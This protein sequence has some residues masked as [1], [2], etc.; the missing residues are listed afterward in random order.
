MIISNRNLE[1]LQEQIKIGMQKIIDHKQFNPVFQEE[2]SNNHQEDSGVQIENLNISMNEDKISPENDR[3]PYCIVWTALPF[4]TWII[5]IIGHTGIALYFFISM[6]YYVNYNNTILRSNGVIHDFAGPYFISVDNFAFGKP[7]K[8]VKIKHE[9]IAKEK[10][11]NAI[12]KADNKFCQMMHNLFC[13]NCHSH[14]ADALNNMGYLGK[15]NWNMVSVWFIC[16]WSSKY[17]SWWKLIQTYLP[18]T[19][20]LLVAFLLGFFG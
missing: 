14:V 11:D 17:V 9:N 19:V 16:L 5:P 7:L 8:Y 12:L 13:N 20:I 3:F 6:S 18:L 10:Y 4:I 2:N 1:Q 15:T